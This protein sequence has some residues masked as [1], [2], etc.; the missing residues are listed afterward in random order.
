[1]RLREVDSRRRPPAGSEP[2]RRLPPDAQLLDETLVAIEIS[3]VKIV[4]QTPALTDQA[5]QSAPRMMIFRVRPEMLGELFDTG[6]EQG[7][8]DFSRAASVSGA[9]V[10]GDNGSLAG[11]LKGH[12]VFYSFP[13]RLFACYNNRPSLGGKAQLPTRWCIANEHSIAPI[14][15]VKG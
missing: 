9:G 14:S 1:M 6:R 7:N 12:Q 10:V 5:Q 8:L 3:C 11:G 4:E 15:C 2:F 13:F